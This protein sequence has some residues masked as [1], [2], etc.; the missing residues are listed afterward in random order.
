MAPTDLYTKVVD[1]T[2]EYLGPAAER[3]IDRIVDFH[4]NKPA[5]E[6]TKRDI[7][8]LADWI[9]VSLGLLTSDKTVVDDCTKKLLRLAR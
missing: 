6:L 2:E 9:K 8:K 4:L 5:D 7:S 3:F 1:V